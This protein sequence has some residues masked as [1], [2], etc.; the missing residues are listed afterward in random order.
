MVTEPQISLTLPCRV[1]SEEGGTSDTHTAGPGGPRGPYPQTWASPWGQAEGENYPKDCSV[2]KGG[3]FIFLILFWGEK[4][5]GWFSSDSCF[6]SCPV[7]STI[8]HKSIPEFG[9]KRPTDQCASHRILA[10][11]CCSQYI[12]FSVLHIMKIIDGTVKK[13][14]GSMQIIMLCNIIFREASS[15]R[16][17]LR[18]CLLCQHPE[19][20]QAPK[21][22]SARWHFTECQKRQNV[23]LFLH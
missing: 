19:H 17:G 8:K 5:I 23:L 2:D 1:L 13:F 11:Q 9:R 16:R 20:S 15:R 3:I 21:H 7:I 10:F 4:S 18:E 6:G 14:F 22:H 12:F